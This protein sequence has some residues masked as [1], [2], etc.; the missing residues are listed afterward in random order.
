M[1]NSHTDYHT[2]VEKPTEDHKKRYAVS[3]LMYKTECADSRAFVVK[4]VHRIFQKEPPATG[5]S[6]APMGR[7]AG[8]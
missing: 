8:G 2:D 3:S 7:E 4:Y 1:G 6:S 5:H